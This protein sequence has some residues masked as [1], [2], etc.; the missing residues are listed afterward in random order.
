MVPE[1]RRG[2]VMLLVCLFCGCD[3]APRYVR[4][5]LDGVPATFR[6]TGPWTP[7]QPAE[8]QPRGAWWAVMGDDELN[9]LEDRIEQGSP[10][11]AAAVARYDQA[12][13]LVRRARAEFFPQIDATASAQR[14]R[15]LFTTT[16]NYY[17]YREYASGG[18]ISWEPDIWGRI[19][20]LVR[21][22]RANAQ[23]SAAD[24]ASVRLSLQAELGEDYFQLRGLDARIALLQRTV[25]AYTAAFDLTTK[26][27]VGGVA[28]E[29]DV[30]RAQ[31]QLTTTQSQLEQQRADRALVEHAI[32]VLIGEQPSIFAIAPSGDLPPVPVIPV[33]APSSLLE[34]RPD[35]ASAERHMA[36][37]NAR[38]GV[39]RAAFFPNITLS[40]TGG[41]ET[42]IGALAAAGTGVWALGPAM[43]TLALFDGGR[44]FANLAVA[45][46]AYAEAA[47]NYRQT[48][49]NAFR[50][51]E[52]Q[53]ALLNHLA[54]A[55]TRQDAAVAAATRTDRLA[56][57]QYREGAVD[58]LQVVIAQTAELQAREDM[59]TLNTRRL[60]S[61]IDLVRAM[62]GGWR[63]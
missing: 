1:W 22:A 11:L 39:A 61:G 8:T 45:H 27:F 37:A 38:I 43:A 24:L 15:A 52:D 57:V 56:G 46:A 20:N 34:R 30:G 62:G 21:A 19:R 12:R 3:L 59:I 63:K 18:A 33:A 13:A 10:Q 2:G 54:D 25:A 48:A 4:P 31:T 9:R 44:R 55:A 47:A 28:N 17:D 42:T 5:T 49:L 16:G 53:L 60:M 29:L 6:E 51:V 50:E 32:A 26:R 36:A 58:Y 7:A 41:S 23:A 40:A 14:E 35:V